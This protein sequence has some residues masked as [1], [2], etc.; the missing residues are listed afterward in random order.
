MCSFKTFAGKVEK[1]AK[2]TK[3]C[4]SKKEIKFEDYLTC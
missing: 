2:R 3:K 1:K 4:V